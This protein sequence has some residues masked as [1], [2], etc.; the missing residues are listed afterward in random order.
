[1]KRN[2]MLL[3]GL[4]TFALVC[5]SLT[6][7]GSTYAKYTSEMT[8][9]DTIEA[10]KYAWTINSAEE[11]TGS[12][13]F[14]FKN[15]KGEQQL[16]APG[17]TLTAEIL[18][19]NKSEVDLEFEFKHIF[20]MVAGDSSAKNPIKYSLTCVGVNATLGYSNT[21]SFSETKDEIAAEAAVPGSLSLGKDGS[22]KLVLTLVWP[23]EAEAPL[24]DEN[25]NKLGRDGASWTVEVT[26]TATQIINT[27]LE[28]SEADALNAAKAELQA[29]YDTFNFDADDSSAKSY[30]NNGNN[31]IDASKTI[32][33]A[34]AALADAKAKILYYAKQV[35][36]NELQEHANG[37]TPLTNQDAEDAAVL[38]GKTAIAA[39]TNATEIATALTAAKAAVDLA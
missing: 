25:D 23:Y 2:R 36:I 9:S 29:Y 22:A 24:T 27:T 34:N 12:F 33:E 26:A 5:V 3:A 6:F 7:V 35:A 11:R 13:T 30:L 16:I 21:I 19:E 14:E 31:A 38:S 28:K 15:T 37:H 18:I 20:D 1:M 17:D 32:A 10:A 39:A 4:F 8:G